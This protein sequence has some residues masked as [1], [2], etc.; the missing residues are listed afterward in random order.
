MEQTR[1]RFL[2]IIFVIAFVQILFQRY[3]ASVVAGGRTTT[4]CS[5]EIVSDVSR[6][7]T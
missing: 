5:T 3:G 1:T 4:N 2:I 7:Y 6:A